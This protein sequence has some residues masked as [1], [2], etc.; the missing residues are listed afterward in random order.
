MTA[1]ASNGHTCAGAGEHSALSTESRPPAPMQQKPPTWGVMKNTTQS[2]QLNS[3]TDLLRKHCGGAARSLAT[4]KDSASGLQPQDRPDL[5]GWKVACGARRAG[6]Y[7]QKS[8][9]L[10]SDWSNLMQT[11]PSNPQFDWSKGTALIGQ[12]RL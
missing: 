7:A 6:L 11:S 12:N 3:D 4:R 9:P 1:G 5:L 10:V 2:K 8:P